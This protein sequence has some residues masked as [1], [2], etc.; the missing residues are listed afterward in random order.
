[1]GAFESNIHASLN[2]EAEYVGVTT[3]QR[4]PLFVNQHKCPYS[5]IHLDPT[6]INLSFFVG[7]EQEQA[8]LDMLRTY[9]VIQFR[10]AVLAMNYREQ[11]GCFSNPKAFDIFIE[12]LCDTELASSVSFFDYS[13]AHVWATLMIAKWELFAEFTYF[14]MALLKKLVSRDDFVELLTKDEGNRWADFRIPGFLTERLVP[15]WVFHKR[16]KSGFVPMVTTEK[17]A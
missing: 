11:W 8:A 10:P 5:K 2:K 9:E 15:L 13:N 17:D 3:Y 6:E 16:L 7:K 1:M 14:Y 12:E 4:Y